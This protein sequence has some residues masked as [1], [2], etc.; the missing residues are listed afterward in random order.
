[1]TGAWPTRY[2]QVHNHVANQHTSFSRSTMSSEELPL[3]YGWVQEFDPKA[4]HPFWVCD[5]SF[6]SSNYTMTDLRIAGG[7]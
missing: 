4:D 5:M 3:P 6:Y 7:Y 1:M 2:K